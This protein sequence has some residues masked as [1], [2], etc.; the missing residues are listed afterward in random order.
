LNIPS[1]G[2]ILGSTPVSQEF[3]SSKEGCGKA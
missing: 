3:T 1:R 2:A